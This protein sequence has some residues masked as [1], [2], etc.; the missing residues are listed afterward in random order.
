MLARSNSNQTTL[1]Y[2]NLIGA[3]ATIP[4]LPF[5]WTTPTDPMVIVVMVVIGAFGSLGHYL[6]IAAHRL[7]QASLLAPFIYS[8]LVWA[9]LAGYFVFG[10]IPS[11]WTIAGAAIVVA[12]G[13]YILNRERTVKG[14]G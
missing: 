3:V 13:L 8:Q 4:V 12:S 1:F 6:L 11:R 2:S 7:A 5:V 10:D 9:G 14:G